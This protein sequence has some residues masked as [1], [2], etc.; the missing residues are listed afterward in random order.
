M[1]QRITQLK[2]TNFRGATQP[3][4]VRFTPEKNG[5]TTNIVVIFGENGTGKSTL[6]DALDAL[7]NASFGS[8]NRPGIQTPQ[9]HVASLTRDVKSVEVELTT[10]AGHNCK[11]IISGKNVSV[12][13]REKEAIIPEIRILRRRDLL[14]L[15]ETTPA[16]R[17][18]AI[19]DFIAVNGVDKAELAL[20]TDL[21]TVERQLSD[22]K[23]A[24]AQSEKLLRALWEQEKQFG[25]FESEPADWATSRVTENVS[26][27]Q[28]QFD[29]LDK[30]QRGIQQLVNAVL[31]WKDSQEKCSQEKSE[32]EGVEAELFHLNQQADER[33]TD[34]INLLSSAERY[35]ALPVEPKECPLCGNG[36]MAE[37]LRGRIQSQLDQLQN[38]RAL[39]QKSNDAKS[40]LKTATDECERCDRELL[41]IAIKMTDYLVA[42]E[43]AT[44]K[45]LGINWQEW[46]QGIIT[47]QASNVTSAEIATLAD[48]L[49]SISLDVE[50]EA[51]SLRTRLTAYNN[52]KTQLGLLTESTVKVS[53]LNTLFERLSNVYSLVVSKRREFVQTILDE[54]I[55]EVNRLYEI[56]HPGEKIGLHRLE[57]DELKR[58]SLEQH[59][60]FDEE[61]GVVPQAY[62]SESHLDTFGFCLWLALAKRG[63]SKQLVLVLDDVFTSV[64]AQHFRRIS[65]L[66][67]S[68]APNFQQ[69][70]IATHNRLWHDYYKMSGASAHL[71]KLER[72]TIA[73]GLRPYEDLTLVTELATALAAD[74]FDRQVVASK[75]GVLLENILD[76][77]AAY[78]ECRMKYKPGRSYTLGELLRTTKKLFQNAKVM[79]VKRDLNG[80]PI[81][82]QHPENW[83]EIVL[84]DYH[85]KLDGITLI[86]NEVGAHFNP[87]GNDW[88]DNDVREFGKAAYDLAEAL[89]CPQC[90]H[91]PK[92]V[93]SDHRGC[94]CD[95]KYQTRLY[96]LNLN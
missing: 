1:P 75:A 38:S 65:E 59:A 80:H 24:Q 12:T 41:R 7:G 36:V 84:K 54:I 66:L 55:N 47:N 91:I 71:L 45:S 87:S 78:Y 27:L 20:R 52:I 69:I 17:Y 23:I 49:S 51:E 5:P 25:E 19:Q 9:K 43:P 37:E 6:V 2:L 29:K 68:E 11:A 79:R 73:N 96:P 31:Q 72:W 63:D 28:S 18:K 13:L 35:L 42:N 76:S 77:L 89:A 21:N 82:P 15:I 14:K 58:A 30:V 53:S 39:L 3:I 86:R 33:G 92:N 46:N 70:I 81:I 95:S 10:Q 60:R 93:R 26:E 22:A 74:Q 61:H 62:F 4:T 44:V 40:R 57:I 67:E 16:E 64:D 8:L 85:E 83:I 90:G 94:S 34:L 48:K 50:R 56:I 32:L 88:S